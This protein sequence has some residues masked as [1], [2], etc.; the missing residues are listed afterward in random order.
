[1]VM[2]I[3][4]IQ[5]DAFATPGS[6]IITFRPHELNRCEAVRKRQVSDELTRVYDVAFSKYVEICAASTWQMRGD[7]NGGNYGHAFGL[8]KGACIAKTKEQIAQA[9]ELAKVSQRDEAAKRGIV[10]QEDTQVYESEPTLLIPCENGVVGISSD[11]IFFNVQWLAS[12]GRDFALYGEHNPGLPFDKNAADKIKKEAVSRG[13]FSSQ[14][15]NFMVQFEDSYE[16][17]EIPRKAK[18]AGVS[19]EDYRPYWAGTAS[20]GTDFAIAAARG[21]V[22]CTRIP[23]RG[24]KKGGEDRPLK[25]LI[26]HLNKMNRQIY[27]IDTKLEIVSADGKKHVKGFGYDGAVNNCTSNFVNALAAVGFWRMRDTSGHPSTMPELILRKS[28]I[29]VPYNDMFDAYK[30]GSEFDLAGTIRK[31]HNDER[32]FRYFKETGWLGAQAGVMLESIPAIEYMNSVYDTTN[33]TSFGSFLSEGQKKLIDWLKSPNSQFVISLVPITIKDIL[34]DWM[35]LDLLNLQPVEPSALREFKRIRGNNSH[36]GTNLIVN[37]EW[38]RDNIY[39]RYL[40]DLNS[41]AF[42]NDEVVEE[43]KSYFSKKSNEINR[44]LL[45]H[46]SDITPQQ[47]SACGDNQ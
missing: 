4:G 37:L 20:L 18:E 39:T 34:R 36:R 1:M 46:R 40:N 30:L 14:Q 25:D 3:N 28:D 19:I 42:G 41:G 21:G 26:G 32:A 35:G 9:V 29:S 7:K 11:Y 16:K 27:Q 23:M 44:L 22:D 13:V 15:S 43:L 31:F 47:V 17:D 24:T 38:W 12:E 45:S 33:K 6:E 2:V 5:G 8:I 10:L